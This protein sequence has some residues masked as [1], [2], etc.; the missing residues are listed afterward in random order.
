MVKKVISFALSEKTVDQ[1]GKDSK[2]LG[3]SRS[4]YV[5]LMLSKGFHFSGDMKSTVDEISVLQKSI[6]KRIFPEGEE[7]DQRI[8]GNY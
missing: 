6:K 2:A 8:L 7:H 3:M 1:I 5:D 4:E